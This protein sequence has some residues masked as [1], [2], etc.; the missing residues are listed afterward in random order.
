MYTY[1]S[2]VAEWTFMKYVMDVVTFEATTRNLHVL[3]F[4]V[5]YYQHEDDQNCD[6]GRRTSLMMMFL[7]I[8]QRPYVGL[9]PV[10]SVCL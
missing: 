1:E 7:P 4:Y 6:V 9:L 5:Q 3:I 2:R 10:V 8:Y